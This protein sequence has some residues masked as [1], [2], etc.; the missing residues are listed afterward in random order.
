M[1]YTPCCSVVVDDDSYMVA[2]RHYEQLRDMRDRGEKGYVELDLVFGDGKLHIDIETISEIC[3]AGP[4][5]CE[6]RAA[7]DMEMKA[8]RLTES[9]EE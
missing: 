3:Y 5:Y 9:S 8:A 2:L 7:H 6:E 4:R 1:K